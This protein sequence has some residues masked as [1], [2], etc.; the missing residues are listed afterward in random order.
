MAQQPTSTK[1]TTSLTSQ[2]CSSTNRSGVVPLVDEEMAM[3]VSHF[4]WVSLLN[5][6]SVFVFVC[7]YNVIGCV[8]P[9]LNICH[10]THFPL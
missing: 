5:N 10:L 8:L 6:S 3:N 7:L 4:C 9:Q 2:I 1:H